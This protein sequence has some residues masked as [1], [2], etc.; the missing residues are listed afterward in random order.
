MSDL[1]TKISSVYQGE[2]YFVCVSPYINDIKTSRIDSFKDYFV[3]K[4][5]D[6]KL[7]GCANNQKGTWLRDWARVMRVFKSR[8]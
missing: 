5:N 8:I 7:F 3:I 6:F 1:L 4:N 2:N